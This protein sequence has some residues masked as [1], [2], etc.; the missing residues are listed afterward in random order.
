MTHIDIWCWNVNL[1]QMTGGKG[2]C[3][4]LVAEVISALFSSEILA[5]FVMWRLIESSCYPFFSCHCSWREVVALFG[6][7]TIAYQLF[8]QFVSDTRRSFDRFPLFPD[9]KTHAHNSSTLINMLYFFTGCVFIDRREA[10]C[11]KRWIEASHDRARRRV[12]RAGSPLQ[13]HPHLLRLR[14]QITVL[15]SPFGICM[16][17]SV[18]ICPVE[19]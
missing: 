19:I 10:G 16:Q 2:L 17:I 4:S 11:D 15:A 6:L 1:I 5:V 13:L 3:F 8:V 14:Y 12:C 7:G 18:E 9:T